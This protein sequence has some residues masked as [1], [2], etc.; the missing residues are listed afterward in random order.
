MANIKSEGKKLKNSIETVK[1]LIQSTNDSKTLSLQDINSPYLDQNQLKKRLLGEGDGKSVN[2]DFLGELIN[3]L[4][5]TTGGGP[6]EVKTFVKKIIKKITNDSPKIT[7]II[8]EELFRA[9]NCE[10]DFS[11]NT[12]EVKF[13]PEEIDF[14]DILKT[15]PESLYGSVMY[16]KRPTT[17]TNFPYPTNRFIYERTTNT[18][19]ETYSSVNG[20]DLFDITFDQF[21]QEYTLT[22]KDVTVTD[23]V[24]NYYSSFELFNTKE[25]MSD[26]LDMLFG[27]MSIDISSKRVKS[28]SELNQL[29]KGIASMCGNFYE[30]DS[31]IKESLID[32][33]STEDEN[34]SFEFDDEDTRYIEEDF[35]LKIKKIYK[36]VDC[37]NFES[38]VNSDLILDTLLDLDLDGLSDSQILDDFLNG[39]GNNLGEDTGFDIPSINLNFNTDIFKQI[40]KTIVGKILSPK[41]VLPFIALTKAIDSA[42]EA[43]KDIVEFSRNNNRFLTRVSTRVYDMYR[44]E[45]VD[46]IRKRL[47][48]LISQIIKEVAKQQLRGRY[49]I[50][51]SLIGAIDKLSKSD[52]TTCAGILRSLL[53]LLNFKTGIPLG[54]P[55]PL[56]YGGYVREGMNSTRAFGNTI[57]NLQKM[58][59]NVDT[60][61]DGSPNKHVL[62][63]EA[64][65]QGLM[66]EIAENGAVQFVS[67]PATGVHPLG[68]VAIPFVTGKGIILSSY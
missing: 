49:A 68:P 57:E 1:L 43:S 41:S 24:A 28:F 54:V 64:Q 51:L 7:K 5:Q 60:L 46:E 35:N 9:I 47:T 55:F 39:L 34:H 22:F 48:Q 63:M 2:T 44:Q 42:K 59:Y 58:G 14:F 29:M 25:I 52:L 62:G 66:K 30:Q 10:T 23:F 61:P 56:L 12:V 53:S 36:L 50:I 18:T 15:N 27:F 37:G 17:V 20:L 45:V 11:L 6:D 4:T 21:D 33:L 3:T 40:P 38:E 19:T 65:M 8:I 16:E 32:R 31:L 67:Q 26:I 13:K